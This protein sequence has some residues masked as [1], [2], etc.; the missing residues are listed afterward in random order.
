M[1]L[2]A[3]IALALGLAALMTRPGLRIPALVVGLLSIPGNVDN[4]VPQMQMDLHA[5]ANNTGPAISVID[6]L[7]LWAVVLTARESR[8][9]RLLPTQRRFVVGA[10]IVALLAVA[11]STGSIVLLGV[12]PLAGIRGMLTFA[13][14]P[15]VLYLAFRLR[16]LDPTGVRLSIAAAVGGVALIG[17]GVY[18]STVEHHERFTAATF[19]VNGLGMALVVVTLLAVG[20]AVEAHNRQVDPRLAVPLA[21]LAMT[22]LF[23]AI[24]TGTRMSL[25][26]LIVGGVGAL[27]LNRS[28]RSPAGAARVAGWVGLAAAVTFAATLTTAGGGR[29]ISTVTDVGNTIDIVTDIDNTDDSEVRTRSEFWDQAIRMAMSQPLTG[30]GPFQWNIERYALDDTAPVL[31]A[32]PHNTYLQVA[33]EYGFVVLAAFVALLVLVLLAIAITQLRRSSTSARAWSAALIAGVAA[34]IPVTE[35]TNSHLFN[36]RLGAFAWLLL[37]AALAIALADAAERRNTRAS[38]AP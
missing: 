25:I 18:T 33:A 32:N 11:A 36:V 23:G 13:R 37:A 7:L 30:V 17:N 38:P 14:I 26:A 19:G 15:A 10:S 27:V 2:A 35:L 31:V 34:A 20:A 22:T 4:L 29:T 6:G 5:V 9:E 12:E 24:A 3:G 28:W 21:I 1:I 16:P 8:H